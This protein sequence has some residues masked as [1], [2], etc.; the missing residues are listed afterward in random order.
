MI[1]TDNDSTVEDGV[2]RS[3]R[4]LPAK[5]C[6]L[7]FIQHK[8][9]ATALKGVQQERTISDT[10]DQSV[11][12]ETVVKMLDLDILVGS[13]GVLS[14]A[15]R[16]SQ[17]AHMLID[18]FQPEGVTELAVDSIFMMAAFGECWR[19]FM[20]KRR[21][22]FSRKDWSDPVGFYDLSGG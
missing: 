3:N 15:P 6:G 8:N 5:H 12:G 18:A 19:K 16:R 2:A 9:F 1:P 4:R 17:A 21:F 11:S 13:G 20:R 7:A 22:R 10:F 14:H